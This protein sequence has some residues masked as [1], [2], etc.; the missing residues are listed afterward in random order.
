MCYLRLLRN[1]VI[2]IFGPDSW[3]RRNSS[4]HMALFPLRMT[5]IRF[6]EDRWLGATSLR[7]QYPA[8]Y[9][10]VLGRHKSDTLAQVLVDN[11]PIVTFRQD[12]VGP[13]LVA[14]Q[15]LVQRLAA[16]NLRLFMEIC[17]RLEDTAR[18]FLFRHGWKHNLRI[19]PPLP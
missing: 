6:W 7:E 10:I 17:S 9:N 2:P 13:R 8:L 12:L 15:E 5:H 11:H 4:S 1:L 3:R 14:G 16:L 18:D 19:D